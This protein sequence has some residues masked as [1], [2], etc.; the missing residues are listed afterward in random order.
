MIFGAFQLDRPLALLLLVIVLPLIFLLV[1]KTIAG[2]G[3]V[4]RRFAI[5]VR[6]LVML[7]LVGA[8]AEPQLRD[9][10]EDLAVTF[11]LDA[12]RSV[13]LDK[14]QAMDSWV[15]G[16]LDG[17]PDGDRL[18]VLTAAED[19]YV[20]SLPSKLVQTVERRYV[21]GV[22]GTDLAGAV[23][24]A[25]AVSPADAAARIVLASDGNETAGSLLAAAQAAL[26]AGVP[27]DV[28]P[29]KYQIVGEVRAD[30]MVVPATARLGQTVTARAVL[31]ATRPTR[32][33][34]AVLV[35]GAPA[36][37]G[38][39]GEAS[40]EVELDTGQNA[41]NVPVTLGTAGPKRFEVVFEPL[42]GSGD[43]VLENNRA[44]AVTF[45]TGR[46]AV[47]VLASDTESAG[48]FLD[49]MA[50][51]GIATEVRSFEQAP[52]ALT[53][54][55]AYDA[56]VMI[57]QAAYDYSEAQQEQ[58]R[59]YVHDTGGG[60]VMIG[61]P[62]SY[63]AGG[64]IGSPLEEALPV[65]L[66]PPQR[67]NMPRG[68]LAIVVHSVELAQGV[69]YGKL[70][71]NAA[72]DA[73]STRDL[74]GIIEF[75]ALRGTVWVHPMAEVGDRQAVRRSINRL[76]FGD[77]PDF[78]PSFRL[79]L[80]GLREANAGQKHM[81]IISDGDPSS[82]SASLLQEFRDA[83]IS[84]TTISFA[85]HGGIDK[86]RMRLIAEATGGRYYDV[87]NAQIAQLPQIF[88]KE[89]Q[90]VR[91]A[92]IWE[93]DPFAPLVEPTGADPMRGIRSVPPL[94]GYV[95]THERAGLAQTTLR[96]PENDPISAIWQHGLGKVVAFTSDAAS[97]WSPDWVVWPDYG[98]FWEQHVRWAMRP[99]GAAD[100]RV[101]TEQRG[102]KTLVIAEAFDSEG[103]R[104]PFAMFE[105]FS[106][107]PDGDLARSA[108]RQ[109]GPGRFEAEVDTED[110]GSY[111]LSL[112]YEVPA[113][114]GRAASRG[115]AQAA[116]SKPFADEFRALEDNEALLAQVAALTGGRVITGAP[117][118]A[119][120]W[121]RDGL[122]MPVST[123]P[124]WLQA[125]LAAVIVF[126]L[127][128]AVRRVRIDLRVIFGG[129]G[130][131][132]GR[133]KE[134]QSAG[135]DALKQVRGRRS[136]PA[137]PAP[138][139]TTFEPTAEELAAAGD[140]SA[141]P[142]ERAQAK[143]VQQDTEEEEGGMSR[144]MRA[145]RRAMEERRDDDPDGD[146]S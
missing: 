45:V 13:P 42:E 43:A 68:A 40:I 110:A 47:L 142:I 67:Q 103:E 25:L 14:Q 60:L 80:Q 5:F 107:E 79:G 57:N 118:A 21:G 90:T 65:Q 27:I 75:E 94:S 31:T 18:G 124:V 111:L 117:Q 109:V 15:E 84:V 98:R 16:S 144:L 102:D 33:R 101:R 99:S 70:T 131:A 104:V 8:L 128:V 63:G 100:V 120:L 46:G 123:Q 66:D 85:S 10:S 121:S 134:T 129:F 41:F 106:A 23:R 77:M 130:R 61:G 91:R 86:R 119:G 2:G 71:A 6:V 32:G 133:S 7:L 29:L 114:D 81:I 146:A 53:G 89:A 22:N 20:Q 95:V 108:M 125:M 49:A 38:A 139:P 44:E 59:R 11:V 132:F 35:D 105:V 116:V 55:S 51:S 97:R 83:N 37:V 138:A 12:S 78:A 140:G 26:A 88:I 143:A 50:E 135:V 87:S 30:R 92:L 36:A 74:V 3:R 64:W 126:L 93:G 141:A 56:V 115:V 82:P 62:E 54:W 1:S 96:G 39:D 58:L 24:L 136:K 9:E 19:A 4:A 122:E 145:K 127:D 48:P 69:F 137:G 34:L 28:F 17:K 73:L 52:T 112:Q 113:G 76:Q 72:V